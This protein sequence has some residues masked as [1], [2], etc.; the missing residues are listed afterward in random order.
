[1][2]AYVRDILECRDRC[3]AHVAAA[4]L[5][6]LFVLFLLALP[7]TADPIAPSAI[8]VIDGDTIGALGKTFRLINFD[9]PETGRAKCPS[10][11]EL[12]HKATRRLQE[13][14]NGGS[15]DLAEVMCNCSAATLGTRKC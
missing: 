4:M 14:I 9:A 11:R 13:I 12:G 5:R 3:R 2:E 1:M 15:L 7:A 10:E 8:R 6:R